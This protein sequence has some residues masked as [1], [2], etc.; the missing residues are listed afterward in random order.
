MVVN[1]LLAGSKVL[2]TRPEQQAKP[3]CDLIVKAGGQAI[4][5]PAIEIVPI[6]TSNWAEI[7]LAE[8]DMII[9][10]S[11]NAVSYFIEALT[12]PLPNQILLASVGAGSAASMHD[13][14]LRVDIQPEKSIG[15]EGLLLMPEFDNMVDKKILIVRGKGGRELLADTLTQRG[16]IVQYLE[17]YERVLP[18]PSVVQCEQALTADY[19]VCTSV[20]GVKNLS[21][22]LQKGLK[23]IVDKPMLVMSERIKAYAA[24]VGFQNIIVTDTSSDKAVVELLTKLT[25]DGR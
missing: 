7:A 24:S 9:F 4:A 25:K 8:Q 13:H 11:R 10:V 12:E 5:F 6:P 21:V 17:V 15:S 1:S 3:L 20:A 2:V 18:S 22:L 14:G 16:G 19:I 23:K